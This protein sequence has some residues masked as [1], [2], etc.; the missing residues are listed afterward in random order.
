MSRDRLKK[1]ARNIDGLLEKDELLAKHALEIAGMRRAAAAELHALFVRFTSEVNDLLSTAHLVLDPPA[2]SPDTYRDFGVNMIQLNV[3]GRII[4]L[5]FEAPERL[6]S[7]EN[8]RVP[9]ILE[10]A[11]RCFNQE[12]LDRDQVEEQLLFYCLEK[13]RHAWRYFDARTYHTGLFDQD[14]LIGLLERI[15]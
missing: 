4:Q 10:G 11:V 7:T 9:Y 1:L 14:Y 6:V 3:R 5:E 12:L 15:V 8:F 2:F 13:H